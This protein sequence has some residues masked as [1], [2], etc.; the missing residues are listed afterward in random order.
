MSSSQR[1]RGV[2]LGRT[3]SI[4]PRF[5]S[6]NR[7]LNRVGS[8][9]SAQVVLP[10]RQLT[11]DSAILDFLLARVGWFDMYVEGE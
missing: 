3:A 7:L 6:R 10:R 9:K 5:Q 2:W 1:R 11:D 8:T 4:P